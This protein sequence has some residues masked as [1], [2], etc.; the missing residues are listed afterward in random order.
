MAEKR[1]MV[2]I[3]FTGKE[4]LENKVFDTT[5]EHMAKEAGI[6]TEGQKFNPIDIILGEKELHEK[7]EKQIE[8]MKEGEKKIVKLLAN[9]AFG[10]RNPQLVR[11]VPLQN[12]IDQKIN[13]FPGLLV[14]VSN[15]VGKIQSVNSGRVRVDFNHPL[16]G[17]DVE[18]HV[19]LLKEIKDKK[20]IAEKIFEKYYSKVP[21]AKKEVAE[22]KMAIT[23]SGDYLKNLEKLNEAV[24]GIAKDFDLEIEFREE[25]STKP[26][27]Q[28]EPAGGK[29]KTAEKAMKEP[30]VAAEEKKIAEEQKQTIK[31]KAEKE[32]IA[33]K[34]MKEPE[35]AAEEKKIAEEETRELVEEAIE[36]KEAPQKVKAIP[37]QKSKPAPE[38]KPVPAKGRFIDGDSYSAIV[39]KTKGINQLAKEIKTES[40]PTLGFE[41]TKDSAST[42]Q[43][44]KRK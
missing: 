26:I 32:K 4:L 39:Q 33:E 20:E 5:L 2:S 42:I 27:T 17:R 35:V 3:N 29:E 34:A 43:R 8:E 44:P 1:K 23:V 30:E 22:G 11:V 6:F 24:K 21:S 10:E 12:F 37:E 14:R 13:P 18:Y 25:G 16:A 15:A 31:A 36:E 40:K 7:V 38:Q 9:E 41:V 28:E 19:E